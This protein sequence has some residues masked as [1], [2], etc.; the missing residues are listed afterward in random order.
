MFKDNPYYDKVD[1]ESKLVVVLQ[2]KLEARKLQLISP[3]S[4]CVQKHEVHELIVSDEESIQ[5]GQE[6]NK[7]AYLGFVKIVKS[8]VIVVGDE[9]VT[10]NGTIG[11]IAGFDETHLPNHLNIVIKVKERLSGVEQGA[12][13]G[14]KIIFRQAK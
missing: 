14:E 13:L 7:I 8:G 4:R 1:V 11:T 6:V 2:G 9:V 3:I 5:P 12:T 10:G